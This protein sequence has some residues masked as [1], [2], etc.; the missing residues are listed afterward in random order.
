M[1]KTVRRGAAVLV[2][3]AALLVAWYHFS[4][5][6]ELNMVTLPKEIVAFHNRES[7]DWDPSEITVYGGVSVGDR[8]YYLMEIG[9][10]LGSVTLRRS[11][12]GRYKIE[13]L[14]YGDGGFRNAIVESEGKKYLLLGGRD[15][16][17]RI[18]GIA[19]SID[20]RSYELENPNPGDYFLLCT[21]IDSRTED[22][23][24]DLAR[25]AFYNRE[26][27]DI[28]ELYDLSGGGL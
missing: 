2:L 4:Y 16:T 9:E 26:G 25:L 1:G 13:Y 27:E 12:T 18:A 10:Y 11:L 17:A 8:E 19:V 24:I 5:P 14:R 23:H 21:E 28:T 15:L 6:V 3:A 7:E 20:G 22:N